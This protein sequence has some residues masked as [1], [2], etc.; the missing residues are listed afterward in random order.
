MSMSKQLTP[1]WRAWIAEL[2]DC[3]V[4][5]GEG[6]QVLHYDGGGEY[7]P[8]FDYFPP[9]DPGSAA[10][11]ATGGQR[12]STLVMYLND[13]PKGGATVFPKLGLE[14]CPAKGAAVY[15]EYT[16]SL[17]QVDPMTLHAGALVEAGEKWIV[18]KWMR[19]RSYGVVPSAVAVASR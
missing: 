19:Q 14:V 13:V 10:Q 7:R 4:D 3:P 11:M 16:N 17:G 5:R 2:M 1:D 12:V 6:L 9:H 8:H 15:F 18:T